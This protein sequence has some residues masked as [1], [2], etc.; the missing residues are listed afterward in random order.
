MMFSA[1]YNQD[2]AM[3]LF[4]K[5]DHDRRGWLFLP[6]A[7]A[8]IMELVPGFLPSHLEV[9][10]VLLCFTD[11]DL[12]GTVTVGRLLSS[13]RIAQIQQVPPAVGSPDI[14]QVGPCSHSYGL[15][16]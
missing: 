9:A 4:R 8:V 10:T 15:A 12:S 14:L 6:D 5:Y 16:A 2:R 11:V 1:A 13:F 7:T 3:A